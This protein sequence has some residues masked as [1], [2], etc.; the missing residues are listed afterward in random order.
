MT[1]IRKRYTKVF[2]MECEAGS[3]VWEQTVSLIGG[4]NTNLPA[5][6]TTLFDVNQDN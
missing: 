1:W 3:N 5:D 4:R 2:T 6:T